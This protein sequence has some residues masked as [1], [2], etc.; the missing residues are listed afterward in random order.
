MSD[1][2]GEA[3]RAM[4]ERDVHFAEQALEEALRMFGPEEVIRRAA[5]HW[6]AEMSGDDDPDTWLDEPAP[7]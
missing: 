5:R 2:D 1:D 4:H 6:A 7:F 3:A